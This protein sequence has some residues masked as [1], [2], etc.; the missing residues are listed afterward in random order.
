MPKSKAEKSVFERLI[1]ADKKQGPLRLRPGD[2]MQ[3]VNF[4]AEV[5]CVRESQFL[6]LSAFG[7]RKRFGLAPR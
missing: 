2:V 3:L 4:L 1:E 6:D 5:D 7:H